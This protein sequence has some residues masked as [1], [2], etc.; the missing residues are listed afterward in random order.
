MILDR[1]EDRIYSTSLS[2]RNPVDESKED[3]S[4][5]PELTQWLNHASKYKINGVRV[6]RQNLYSLE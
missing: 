4:A 5:G 6:K 3:T 2:V 1:P